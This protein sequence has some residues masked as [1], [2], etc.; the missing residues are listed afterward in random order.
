MMLKVPLYTSGGGEGVKVRGGPKGWW[1]RGPN[2][3][4]AAGAIAAG[5]IAAGV[6][7]RRLP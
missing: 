1:E 6:E 7:A 3:M 5:A 2:K 4:L